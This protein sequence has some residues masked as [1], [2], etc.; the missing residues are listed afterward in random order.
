MSS[1][2][3]TRAHAAVIGSFVGDAAC[4]GMHWVYDTSKL[5]DLL[6]TSCKTETPEFFSPPSCPFYTYTQGEQSPWGAEALELIRYVGKTTD[7]DGRV[8]SA[9]SFKS[10]NAYTGRL[11]GCFKTFRDN[12]VNGNEWDT[13]AD[14]ADTQAHSMVKVPTLVARY[15][16]LEDE[17]FVVKMMSYFT[18]HQGNPMAPEFG[19]ASSLI[20]KRIVLGDGIPDAVKWTLAS[21]HVADHVKEA[22]TKVELK[23]QESPRPSLTAVAA[24]WGQH[25]GNPAVFMVSIYCILTSS[26]YT[27][28]IRT[29]IRAGGDNC[30]R[31]HMIGACMA[32]S[33]SDD[34]NSIPQ[35]W[36]TMTNDFDEI[37]KSLIK[38]I[39]NAAL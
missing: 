12:Y 34:T 35:E 15:Y 17:A 23:V 4:M 27:D 11:N 8:Y 32:A 9:F 37:T 19:V 2:K 28:A 38:I 29:N 10:I 33:T 31:A 21:S 18:V 16:S 22:L 24:E 1:L 13:C 14:P 30:S 7:F 26:N 5:E 36:K 39:E 25:C 20:L 6:K 3:T